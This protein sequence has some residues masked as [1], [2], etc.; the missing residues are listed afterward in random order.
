MPSDLGAGP[1][2]EKLTR[3]LRRRTD[4]FVWPKRSAGL[5]V[6]VVT[7]AGVCIRAVARA[8]M[9][10]SLPRISTVLAIV[11]VLLGPRRAE[12]AGDGAPRESRDG[13]WQ[14]LDR[15]PLKRAL[16]RTGVRPQR[17][18]A[19]A[20]D[21]ERLL[22]LLDQAP[23][24]FTDAAR[25]ASPILVIP[26]PDGRFERF[27]IAESPVMARTLAEKHPQIRTFSGVGID[28]PQARAR[29]DWTPAGFHAQ[30][31][32][33]DGAVYVDPY[34]RADTV[35]Y[36]SYWKR[37]FAD[38]GHVFSCGIGPGNLQQ[39]RTISG[40]RSVRAEHTLRTYRLAVGTTFEYTQ[41]HG[42][43]VSSA[44]AEVVTAIN[45]VTG[46]YELELAVRLVLI[47]D[48]D[49]LISTQVDDGYT[50]DDGLA[51]L[52]ENRIKLNNVVGSNNYDIGHVF[53]TGGGGLA[54]I[55]VVCQNE[56][57]ARK[58]W[59]VTGLEDPIGD[60]F[61]VDFVAHEMGHQFGAHHTFNGIRGSCAGNRNAGTAYEPGS[62][63][64]IMAYAGICGAD[65]LQ[66]NSDP[67][68]HAASLAEIQTYTT[69]SFG[70]LCGATMSTGNSPPTV[71]AGPNLTIPQGTPFEL[72]AFG[73]DP[74]GDSLTYCW[75]EF[76]LGPAQPVEAPDNG[77]SPILRSFEPDMSPTRVVPRLDDLLTGTTAIGEQLPTTGRTM[78]FRVTI[79]DNR[80]GGGGTA[81]DTMQVT[82]DA[83][84]GPFEVLTPN[85]AVV[86]SSQ[87][88]QTVIWSVA[89]TDVAPV[90]AASVDVRL[91]VDGGVTFPLTLAEDTPNDGT[92]TV[93]LPNLG[94]AAARIKVQA[95]DN[96]FFDISDT[97]FT[98]QPIANAPLAAPPPHDRRKNRYVSF[99]PNPPGLVSVGF[100]VELLEVD[101]SAC[102]GNGGRCR[103]DKGNA[104]C[105]VCSEA[106]DP[107][108]LEPV[109]CFW[110]SD[111][112][113]PVGQTCDL[114]GETCIH[115]LPGSVGLSWWVG[116]PDANGV[117]R[118]VSQPFAHFSSEWPTL[119]HVGDCEVVPTARY[120]IRQTIDGVDMSDALEVATTARPEGKYWGDGVGR[121][122]YF[123]DGNPQSPTCDPTSNDCPDEQPCL[124]A[125]PPPDGVANF[126]D[127][128]AA[129]FLFESGPDDVLPHFTWVDMHGDDG[130]SAIYAPPNGVANF[131]DMQFIVL[132]FQGRPY[133]FADPANC[134]DVPP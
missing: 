2:G 29:I 72:T 102:S 76:D 46:I 124:A 27:R 21:R 8:L 94:T 34:W 106:V 51:M 55:G 74:D 111:C 80:D 131:S 126:D 83:S 132:A 26:M 38:P 85:T 18:Q 65:D 84:S 78:S 48:N 12:A 23:M 68:F 61:Y 50:N 66:P 95:S 88:L 24:E 31:L 10:T 45:R 19:L 1:G 67:Y 125:W 57:T 109:P 36:A 91:S 133:P 54:G 112:Q 71:D 52:E 30:I 63:S 77:A 75:E 104:D 43:S 105:K 117:A 82:V 47:D 60:P 11:L 98:I 56:P 42:G 134:P 9:G 108:T 5:P 79:R 90:N 64:T 32:T 20:L 97:A 53:S 13:V 44:L 62:G 100:H 3:I 96:V 81:R 59:G 87:E 15:V 40:P 110:L 129:L 33:P 114:T 116:P 123:C 14:V 7:I 58:A 70:L 28:D 22:P 25:T 120:S 101:L 93:M 69:L 35:H 49:L 122:T 39:H 73:I 121:L 118:L 107:E 115:D 103:L 92:A 113:L 119:V 89:G 127:V 41:F 128:L 37:D 130:S 16:G 99:E 6:V 17:F 86:W 4:D